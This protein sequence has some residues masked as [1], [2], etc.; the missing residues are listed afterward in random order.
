[1]LDPSAMRHQ[2]EDVL[3]RQWRRV[4]YRCGERSSYA[5]DRKCDVDACW[6]RLWDYRHGCVRAI[7]E[8][9]ERDKEWAATM[10][11][12]VGLKKAKAKGRLEA[13]AELK[14]RLKSNK[15]GKLWDYGVI[16][17]FVIE[18][19]AQLKREAGE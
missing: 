11:E 10:H 16:L 14:R 19:I 13:Y 2:S 7:A 3:F 1:M 18:R 17:E 5:Y 6:N 8:A 12:I 15:P 4:G 9:F